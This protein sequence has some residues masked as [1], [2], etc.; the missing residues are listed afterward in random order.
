MGVVDNPEFGVGGRHSVRHGPCI[1]NDS[2]GAR[3]ER[4]MRTE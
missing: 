3:S 4:Q 1:G 2:S